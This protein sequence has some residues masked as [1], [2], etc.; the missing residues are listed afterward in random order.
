M[1]DNRPIGIFDSGVGGLTT[2]REIKN[3]FPNESIIYFGDSKHLPYG[4][5]SKEVIIQYSKD[6]TQFLIDQN[7]K[8]IIV[9]CNTASSNALK[10]IQEVASQNNVPVLDVITPVAEKAAYGFYQKMG[11]IATK[12]TVNSGVYKKRIRKFNKH[13]QVQELATPLLVPVI[14]EDVMRSDISKAVLAHYLSNKK[15]KDIDS[16]ILGC[17]HYPLIEREIENYFQGTVK[18][19]DSPLIV[20]HTLKEILTKKGIENEINAQGEYRFYVSDITK[21]F[22]KLAK[23]FFGNKISLELKLLH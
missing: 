22:Q 13:I 1:S 4:N 8:V 15:L 6:I 14:E 7:C 12:A 10:E 18:V 21:N 5:K 11:V 2:A 17:T 9:A 3:L 16:I 23:K 19:I 20:A